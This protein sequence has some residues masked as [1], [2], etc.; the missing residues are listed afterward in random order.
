MWTHVIPTNR[1][2]QNQ[3]RLFQELNILLNTTIQIL[4]TKITSI[5]RE[6]RQERNMISIRFPTRF[7]FDF[8]MN[9][10]QHHWP[11]K[12]ILI[13][14]CQHPTISMV[15]DNNLLRSKELLTNNNRAECF[16][17]SSS[18]ITN[19]LNYQLWGRR[20]HEHHPLEDQ[21]PQ[22][23]QFERPYRL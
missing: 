21:V 22:R 13:R 8:R 14:K 15:N 5:Q 3:R 11:K 9:L 20:V 2:I 16:R 18:S 19:N 6:I 4:E 1:H 10:S 17:R 12:Y 7:T 23:D